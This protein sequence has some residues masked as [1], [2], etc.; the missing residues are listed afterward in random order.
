M[1]PTVSPDEY[2]AAVEHGDVQEVCECMDTLC[3]RDTAFAST[4]RSV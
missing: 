2:L 1:S 3:A 4:A